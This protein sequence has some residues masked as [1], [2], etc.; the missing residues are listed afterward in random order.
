MTYNI[1]S[2]SGFD[3]Q[4]NLTRQAQVMRDAHAE[5]IA[6]QEVDNRYTIFC[7]FLLSEPCDM[8]MIKRRCCPL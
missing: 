6:L 4:Y 7:N 1:Q 8:Q 2:G 5:I 3:L